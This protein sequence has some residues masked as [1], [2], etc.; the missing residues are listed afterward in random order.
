M[1]GPIEGALPDKSE[2]HARPQKHNTSNRPAVLVVSERSLTGLLELRQQALSALEVR[3][4][5]VRTLARGDVRVCKSVGERQ[6]AGE[7]GAS[8]PSVDDASRLLSLRPEEIE[9]EGGTEDGGDKDTDEDV[10]RC[11]ADEVVVVD[12]DVAVEL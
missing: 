4:G 7:D 8:F 2:D 12:H 11:D 6:H 10:V 5:K 1:I 9:E 3:A